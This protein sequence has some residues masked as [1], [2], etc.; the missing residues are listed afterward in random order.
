M[1][2]EKELVSADPCGPKA[3]S[4][5]MGQLGFTGEYTQE[6]VNLYEETRE[7]YDQRIKEMNG[8]GRMGVTATCDLSP[9]KRQC[10]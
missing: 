9:G 5:Y 4:G 10:I 3:G 2:E 1:L 8:Q 7:Y 6:V